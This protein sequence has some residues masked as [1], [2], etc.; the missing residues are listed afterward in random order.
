M[1]VSRRKQQSGRKRSN[2]IGG[3]LSRVLKGIYN[4][5][6][7]F[8]K[9]SFIT[10]APLMIYLFLGA[11]YWLALTQ[12]LS[13]PESYPMFWRSGLLEN[14]SEKLA[15][16]LFKQKIYIG[17]YALSL[18]IIMFNLRAFITFFWRER[19]LLIAVC[20]LLVTSFVSDN[21]DRVFI[22]V[23]HLSF[24]IIAVWMYL[25]HEKRKQDL[26]KYC[27]MGVAIPILT[28]LTLS[29]V[30]Y[31]IR[32]P[33]FLDT[34]LGD[35]RYSGLSGNPN[36][37]GATCAIGAWA[38]FTLMTRASLGSKTMF[39]CILAVLVVLFNLATTGS[40]TAQSIVGFV[41]V[42]LILHRI[43]SAFNKKV[44]AALLVLI[45]LPSP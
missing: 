44:K 3:S 22:G 33:N 42:M 39:I 37:L 41:G 17:S 2:K 32:E 35:S 11:T 30:L 31:L 28:N 14:P 36:T 26:L 34:L 21:P 9:S 13:D 25:N 16:E 10:A 20:I 19:T 15:A 18:V 23:M 5:I 43:S 7:S 27:C 4:G 8:F 38:I 6:G 40:A 45:V 24:G 1:T 12:M 29:M